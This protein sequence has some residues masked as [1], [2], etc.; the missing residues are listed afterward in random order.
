MPNNFQIA[1]TRANGCTA[2]EWA[3]LTFS[4]QADAIYREIRRLE[5][6]AEAKSEKPAVRRRRRS[7]PVDGESVVQAAA[8]GLDQQLVPYPRQ[9]RPRSR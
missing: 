7:T 1:A 3:S 6:E 9:G 4:E 5:T 2:E 8:C